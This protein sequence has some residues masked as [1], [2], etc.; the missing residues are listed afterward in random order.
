[1]NKQV[2]TEFIDKKIEKD[3]SKVVV[4]Y[5][6]LKVEM[7]LTDEELYNAIELISTRLENLNYN[8]YETGDFYYYNGN[9]CEVQINELLVA[10]K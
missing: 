7:N 1:M 3:S 5:Y 8:V 9:K 10:I 6:K 4:E 2:L